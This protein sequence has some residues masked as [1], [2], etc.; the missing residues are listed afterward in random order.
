MLAAF[1]CSLGLG[2][3]SSH[4][5]TVFINEIHYDNASTD[6]NEG[7]EVAGPAGTD[8]SQYA[9]VLYNGSNGA[10]YN[11]VALSGTISSQDD[12][13]GTA[14]FAISGIQNGAPDGVALV[15][16]TTVI[17]FLSYEGSFTAVSAAR[18]ELQFLPL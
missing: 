1:L 14:F 5:Q 10:V 17:Q 4:A 11:T 6:T 12:G 7:I 3:Y 13:Y 2:V 16:D 9:L 15:Q 18:E 8:L